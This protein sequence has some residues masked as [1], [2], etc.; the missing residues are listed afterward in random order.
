MVQDPTSR[1]NPYYSLGSR[2]R[3]CFSGSSFAFEIFLISSHLEEKGVYGECG[4]IDFNG[5]WGGLRGGLF[6][7]TNRDM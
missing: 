3:L 4:V 6:S 7:K 1:V 2:S 5:P